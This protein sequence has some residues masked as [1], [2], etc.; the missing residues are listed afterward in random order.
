MARERTDGGDDCGGGVRGTTEA[1]G[2]V[3]DDGSVSLPGMAIVDYSFDGNES[4]INIRR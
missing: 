4:R 1:D 2:N 3:S